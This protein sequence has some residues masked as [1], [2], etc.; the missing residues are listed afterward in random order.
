MSLFDEISDEDMLQ[1]EAQAMSWYN[2]GFKAGGNLS[3]DTMDAMLQRLIQLSKKAGDVSPPSKDNYYDGEWDTTTLLSELLDYEIKNSLAEQVKI[4]KK[5][6]AKHIQALKGQIRKERQMTARHKAG[7]A[8]E[9]TKVKK[10]TDAMLDK[11]EG[12]KQQQLTF[13]VKAPLV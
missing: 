13:W 3:A 12:V 2:A 7:T 10:E 11:L 9:I 8:D 4:Q 6:V 1:A 5:Q